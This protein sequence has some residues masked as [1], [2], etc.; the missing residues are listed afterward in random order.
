MFFFFCNITIQ[1]KSHKI[2]VRD[3]QFAHRWHIAI[4]A[5]NL[6]MQRP[7]TYEYVLLQIFDCDA[8]ILVCQ[9]FC[10]QKNDDFRKKKLLS[11]TK[12]K[13]LQLNIFN[14]FLS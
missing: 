11:L 2:Y 9:G 7:L 3:L 4:E 14:V 10:K 8:T 6:K 1:Y 13:I 12:V 5:L